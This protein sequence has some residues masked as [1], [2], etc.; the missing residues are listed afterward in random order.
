MLSQI[1][2]DLL[3]LMTGNSEESKSKNVS[4]NNRTDTHKSENY[5]DYDLD[6]PNSDK[7]DYA[8]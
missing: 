7:W 2:S 3:K 1:M 5:S 4:F 8:A 6:V